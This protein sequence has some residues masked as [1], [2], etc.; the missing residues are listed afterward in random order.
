MATRE[1][2]RRI[3]LQNRDSLR[4]ILRL[5][6]ERPL[7]KRRLGLLLVLAGGAGFVGVLA[8]DLLDAGRVGGVGPTQSLALGVMSLIVLVGLSLLPLGDRPA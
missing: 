3:P 7:S 4:A 2:T 6:W 1:N 5:M 8:V